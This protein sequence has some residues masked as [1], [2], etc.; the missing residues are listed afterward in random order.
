MYVARGIKIVTRDVAL[1]KG[2]TILDKFDLVGWSGEV[3]EAK[4][5]RVGVP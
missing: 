5:V 3:A 1:A 4:L 2:S